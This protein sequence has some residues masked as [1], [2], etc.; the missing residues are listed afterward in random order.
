M[1]DAHP[2][3]AGAPAGQ[4]WL[5][6]AF[7]LMLAW[8]WAMLLVMAGLWVWHHQ[9]AMAGT[10]PPVLA[11]M[12]PAWTCLLV[13]G[14]Q[15]VFLF[16]VADDLCPRAPVAMSFFLKAFTGSVVWLSILWIVMQS[17]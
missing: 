6:R 2:R 3:T 11:R 15:F 4:G 12:M 14:G 10:L 16:L 13:G 1:A 5:L 7:R 9:A 17:W 8:L